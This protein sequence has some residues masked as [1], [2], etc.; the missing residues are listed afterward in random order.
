[1]ADTGSKKI[2]FEV[3]A[4]EKTW[5]FK[6]VRA[7]GHTSNIALFRALIDEYAA[8]IGFDPRPGR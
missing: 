8:K 6:L 4:R 7:G 5:F 1:M 3:P 2:Y